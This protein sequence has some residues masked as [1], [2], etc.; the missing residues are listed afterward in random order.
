VLTARVLQALRT[1][2]ATNDIL[3]THGVIMAAKIDNFFWGW[4]MSNLLLELLHLETFPASVK[5][6]SQFLSE[7]HVFNT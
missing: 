7:M 4:F 6:R 1:K 3:T 5:R 2:I